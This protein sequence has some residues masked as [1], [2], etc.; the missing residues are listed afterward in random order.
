MVRYSI[1]GLEGMKIFEVVDHTDDEVYYVLGIF[2]TL[3]DAIEALDKCNDPKKLVSLGTLEDYFRVEIF[4]RELGFRPDKK[5][6][7]IRE[8]KEVYD[9]ALDEYTWEVIE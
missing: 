6:V 9:E 7:C 2:Q 4:E 3:T 1:E 8:W 5:T